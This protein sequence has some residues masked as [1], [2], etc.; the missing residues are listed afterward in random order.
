[1]KRAGLVFA[2]VALLFATLPISVTHGQGGADF[3]RLVAVGD[4]LTAGF[5]DGAL[6][7]DG[8]QTGFITHVAASMDTPIVLPLIATPGIPTPNPQAGQGLLLLI[9][10]QCRVGATTFATGQ[11]TGRL[12]P[13]AVATDV[14]VPGQGL[15]EALTT[16]WAIDPANPAGTADTAEDF[17][18]GFPYAILPAPANTP[19]SQIELA[20]GLQPTFLSIW[21]GSN[22]A[23]GAALAAT[24]NDTTLT[25]VATF[26]TNADAVFGEPRPSS[27]TS[28]T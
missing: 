7:D 20:V 16:K 2:M 17:V 3:T 24:V 11:T 22:D 1:M 9:P 13:T 5:Q 12:D 10:G 8:Q 14:A 25:P 28:R 15:E 21:L 27:S 6:H 4:S 19:R 23:L 18:L 26:N